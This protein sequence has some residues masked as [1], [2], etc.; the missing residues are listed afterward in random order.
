MMLSTVLS[1]ASAFTKRH[2]SVAVVRSRLSNRPSSTAAAEGVDQVIIVGGG[3]AGLATAAALQNIAN[4][5]KIQVLEKSSHNSFFQKEGIGAGAQ[6]G[7][8][9]L[10]ALHAIGGEELLQR[11][12]DSGS[13][14]KGNAIFLPGMSDPMMQPDTTEEDSGLPQVFVRWSVLRSNLNDL[15]APAVDVQLNA[16]SDICGYEVAGDGSLNIISESGA[17]IASTPPASAPTSLIVG[18]DG[19]V[20]K[21]R[22]W[23]Q[24]GQSDIPAM[25]REKVNTFDLADTGRINLKAVVPKSLGDSFE[26]GHTYSYFAPGGGVACFAGPAGDG[27]TYWAI[28]IADE[29]DEET[30]QV[31]QFMANKS[32]SDLNKVKLALLDKISSLGTDTVKF[33]SDMIEATDPKTIYATRSKEAQNIGPSLATNDGKV[34]LVGDAAHAMSGAYGQNPNFALEGAA[35]LAT[36][37]RNNGSIESALQ[38]YSSMRVDRCVEMQKRSAERAAKAMKGEKDLEDVSAWIHRWDVEDRKSVV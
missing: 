15:L 32:N 18:A 26:E 37:I 38:K 1:S 27:H 31:T 12:I 16:G 8:N 29:K 20:S 24:T 17:A 2:T 22:Y 35:E 3:I 30:G 21:C 14:L 4:V 10:R 9:G 23:I 33:A 36:C 19:A 6:L 5:P 25:E 28:S 13:I 11:V 34:V 7:P